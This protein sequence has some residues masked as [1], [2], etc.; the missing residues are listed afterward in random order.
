MPVNPHTNLDPVSVLV[1]LFAVFLS[2]AISA[3]LGPY[4]VIV[5]AAGT[6]AAW[7]LG[8][9]DP[10]SKLSAVW[11]FLRVN[12]TACILTSSVVAVLNKVYASDGVEWSF[13]LVAFGIGLI[14]DDWKAVC[15]W[16]ADRFPRRRSGD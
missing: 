11:F 16:L 6:G 14:G 15:L 1:T 10:S 8:R 3:V 4:A 7:S 5:L 13:A 12:L 2:P 9:R